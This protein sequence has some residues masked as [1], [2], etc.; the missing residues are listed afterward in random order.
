[1]PRQTAG[2]VVTEPTGNLTATALAHLAAD[3]ILDKKGEDLAVIDVSEVTDIADYVVLATGMNVRQTRATAI[4]ID[5]VM[6]QKGRRKLG[7]HG[8]D[9]GRWVLV[10]YGDV[11]VHL[12]L[13]DAR[14]FYDLDGLW[15]DGRVVRKVE[16]GRKAASTA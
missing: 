14:R 15:G 7:M 16:S 9:Q 10:D 8:A 6:K 3:I 2:E 1:M 12:L 4:E 5:R 11:V 13:D